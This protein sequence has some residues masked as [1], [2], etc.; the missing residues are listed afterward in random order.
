MNLSA[1]EIRDGLSALGIRRGMAVMVHSSLSSFGKVDGGAD[2]VIEAI[3]D[4]LGNEGT[5]LMPSFASPDEIF[6][7]RESPCGL[8]EI[9]DVFWRREDVLRSMHPTH[10]VAARGKL[11]AYFLSGHEKAPTAYGEGTPYKRLV[12]KGG[13]VLMMGADLDRMTLLHAAEALSDAPY[14]TTVRDKYRGEDG[15]I[16]EIAVER[17]AGPHRNF[18]GLEGAFREGGFMRTGKVGGAV[19]RLV[20]AR[21][22]VSYC[23][24][25]MAREPGLMLCD[26]P[27]C[28]DCRRQR[29]KIR[30]KKLE[31]EDFILSASVEGLGH[32]AADLPSL[33]GFEGIKSAEVPVSEIELF[34]K[35]AGEDF[36]VSAVYLGPVSRLDEALFKKSAAAAESV[37]A[38]RVVMSLGEEAAV[39][40]AC[41]VSGLGRA[42]DFLRDRKIRLFV[43]NGAR[44]AAGVETVMKIIWELK[45]ENLGLAYN[46]AN[47]AFEGGRPFLDFVRKLK[48]A[49]VVYVN[50]GI[51]NSPG[52]YTLPGEGNAEIKEIVSALRARSFPGVF[53]LKNSGP[54]GPGLKAQAAAF[55]RLMAGM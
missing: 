52:E 22:A 23:V 26:N 9:S 48:F 49:G 8:G 34:Q 43:E 28:E 15:R 2:T 33:L 29:G 37:K 54:G 42:A 30:E 3:I 24:E 5:L 27:R 44:G 32:A 40:T 19:C 25:R 6:D 41:A 36:S 46:P 14:L 45:N 47:F 20:D 11:A 17:M 31:A 18:I 38:C 39:E 4:V 12:D 1:K 55:R 50:D 16:R 7:Y 21:A 10:S 53:T 51:R 13:Y 35:T